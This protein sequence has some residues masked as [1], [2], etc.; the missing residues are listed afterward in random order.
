MAKTKA[1]GRKTRSA[2]RF[3][4]RYG[5]KSRKLVADIEEKMH[6]EYTCSRCGAKRVRR[7]ATGIWTCTKCEATFTGGSYVPQTPAHLTVMR[8]VQVERSRVS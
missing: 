5:T 7:T 1:K 2:G 4:V 8:A 6:A 3:G